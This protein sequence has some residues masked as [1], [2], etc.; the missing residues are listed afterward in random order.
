[1]QPIKIENKIKVNFIG[2]T[3]VGKTTILERMR[4]GVFN[5]DTI[6]T[7][8]GSFITLRKDGINF[9]VWDTAGQERYLSLIPMYFRGVNIVLFVFD[10]TII[11]SIKY[12]NKY[13]DVFSDR[14]NVKIIV[15]G[16]KTDLLE[17]DYS[18]DELTSEVNDNFEKLM[19]TDRIHGLYFISAKD[20]KNFDKIL[21]H[22]CECAKTLSYDDEDVDI[23]KNENIKKE[24]INDRCC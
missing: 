23:I 7:V 10:V 20:G 18:L 2:N 3:M 13:R 12:I 6:A 1:M 11:E 4:I 9:E 22:L 5:P 16:N 15:L 17:E 24:E 21:E 19:L 8:G 14:P